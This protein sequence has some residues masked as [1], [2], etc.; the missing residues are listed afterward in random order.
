VRCS[1]RR[2]KGRKEHGAVGGGGQGTT[3]VGIGMRGAVD[4]QGGDGRGGGGDKT[5]DGGEIT[6]V[7]SN[8]C[9]AGGNPWVLLSIYVGIFVP[10]RARLG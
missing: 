7:P 1:E 2:P 3:A 9:V 4:L 5:S 8:E 10:Q 6:N